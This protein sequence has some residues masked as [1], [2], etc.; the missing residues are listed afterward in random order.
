MEMI[1]NFDFTVLN[2][3]QE[4]LRNGVMDWLANMLSYMGHAG[5][6]WSAL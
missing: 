6:G 2:F 5:L 3:I 4:H 1:I